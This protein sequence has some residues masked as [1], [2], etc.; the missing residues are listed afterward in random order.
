MAK[1]SLSVG[2]LQ[3]RYGDLKALEMAK[4]AGFDAVDFDVVGYGKRSRPDVYNM[5]HDE[6]LEYFTTVK[7][8]ADELGIEI[9]QTHNLVGAYTP[10][11]QKNEELLH[12]ANCGIEAS[13]ILGTDYTVVHCISTMHWGFDKTAKE[14]HIENQNMY[15]QIL[16]CA[17]QFKVKMCLETFGR[18]KHK[19]VAGFD[20]FAHPE[21]MFEE[22]ESIPTDMK[23]FCMDTG[24]TN[25]AIDAG[26][27]SAGNFIRMFGARTKVLHLHDNN[28][29][30]DQHLIPGQGT[31]NWKDTFNALEEVGY[32]GVYNYE[33]NLA[34]LGYSLEDTVEYLGKYLRKFTDTFVK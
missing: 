4:K 10:D 22:Y 19:G 31:I 8:K 9:A 23:A 16:P 21:R 27:L 7:N 3:A 14:M 33:I 2:T 5:G 26:F 1:I 34:K 11:A 28:G 18:C 20:H 15:A 30:S 12:I 32:N 29:C 25:A 24:H 13:R 17:E 6:F